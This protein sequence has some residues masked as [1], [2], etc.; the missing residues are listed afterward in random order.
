MRRNSFS[1]SKTSETT[2]LS[3]L[4]R[5]KELNTADIAKTKW[6]PTINLDNAHTSRFLGR[7]V[8]KTTTLQVILLQLALSN[9]EMYAVDGK[10]ELRSVGF[11]FQRIRV[12]AQ[13]TS[14]VTDSIARLNERQQ[15][16]TDER[17][18]MTK[19]A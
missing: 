3:R 1:C 11:I 13:K 6:G 18:R 10:D 2:R 9:A 14:Y 15:K 19:R 7:L 4:R 16:K 12:R 17:A 8:R 5:C